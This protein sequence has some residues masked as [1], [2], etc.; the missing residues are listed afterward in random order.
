VRARSGLA[1]RRAT[2]RAR[3]APGPAVLPTSPAGCSPP[4][5]TP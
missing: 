3:R 5:R 2:R 4:P 1:P